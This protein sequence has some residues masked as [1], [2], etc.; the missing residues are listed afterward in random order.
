M[1]AELLNK[2]THAKRTHIKGRQSISEDYEKM[3][4]E[5][6]ALQKENESLKQINAKLEKTL[7]ALLE[8]EQTTP[9]K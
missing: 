4:T 1:T 7:S 3:R 9:A 5:N 2:E 6:E 8:K